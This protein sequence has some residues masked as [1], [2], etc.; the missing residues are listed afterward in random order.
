MA[1]MNRIS[2]LASAHLYL[3]RYYT[4]EKYGGYG[5]KSPDITQNNRRRTQF[6]S[7]R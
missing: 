1:S 6:P 7:S 5:F 3:N 4:A 2:A